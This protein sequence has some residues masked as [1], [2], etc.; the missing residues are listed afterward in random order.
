MGKLGRERVCAL[1]QAVVEKPYDTDVLIYMN[2]DDSWVWKFSFARE[3]KSMGMDVD[4][5][6]IS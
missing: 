6:N 2:D 5:N 3:M 1:L 4:M